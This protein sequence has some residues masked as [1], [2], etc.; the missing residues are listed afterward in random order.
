MTRNSVII[1]SA[2]WLSLFGVTAQAQS[3]DDAVYKYCETVKVDTESTEEKRLYCTGYIRGF[4]TAVSATTAG[5]DGPIDSGVMGY[6]NRP[7]R[8]YPV[9]AGAPS[10][11]SVVG[12]ETLNTPLASADLPSAPTAIRPNLPITSSNVQRL[13][14][15]LG[16]KALPDQ[17]LKNL[18]KQGLDLQEKQKALTRDIQ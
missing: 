5:I 7:S 3:D 4:D 16:A 9:V 2:L 14:S 18:E 15:P 17:R 8:E 6:E 11:P 10:A 13:K 12:K 1:S